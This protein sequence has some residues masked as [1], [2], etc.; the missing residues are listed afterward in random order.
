MEKKINF[1]RSFVMPEDKIQ[2]LKLFVGEQKEKT[3]H[4]SLSVFS[5]L[6]CV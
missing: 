1:N 2:M 5:C 6:C 4:V 3:L